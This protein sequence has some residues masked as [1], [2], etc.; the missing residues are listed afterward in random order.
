[1]K[2]EDKYYVPEI[3]DFRIGFEYEFQGIPKGWHKMIFSEEDNLKTM[4]YNIEKLEDAIRVPY[5]SKEQ[6]EKEGWKQRVTEDDTWYLGEQRDYDLIKARKSHY[7]IIMNNDS[8]ITLFSGEI[9]S[10]NEFRYICKL[11]KI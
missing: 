8:D 5:L 2:E 3:S 11:L 7:Y 9:K 6:I 1:M 4:R 10:I